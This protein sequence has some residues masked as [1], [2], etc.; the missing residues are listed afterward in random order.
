MASPALQTPVALLIFN[1]PDLTARVFAAIA[2]QKPRRLLVVADGPRNEAERELCEQTRA[3]IDVDWEC[4]VER[5]YSHGNLGCKLRVSSGLDW[6]FER[7]PEAIILEDDCLPSPDFFGFCAEM[8]ERYR[9][10]ERV[11]HISGDCF[12]PLSD[13]KADYGF[14]RYV[15]VWGWATWRRAWQHY[16]VKAARWATVRADILALCADKNEARYWNT[17]FE[18]VFLGELDTWDY[19]WALACWIQDGLAVVPRVNLV[20][21][22]GFRADATHTTTNS[23]LAALPAQSFRVVNHPAQ[24]ERDELADARERKLLIPSQSSALRLARRVLGRVRRR[25]GR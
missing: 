17:A 22:L 12:V 9:D 19:Q 20:S 13:G 18:S 3:V 10:D 25:G 23:K 7:A 1:R 21:N 11:M 24:V 2:A 6:V 8:L 15:H 16:D 4:E 5:L 14:S